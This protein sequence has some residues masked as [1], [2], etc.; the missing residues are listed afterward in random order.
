MIFVL[1]AV[2]GLVLMVLSAGFFLAV[3]FGIQ[4]QD[5]FSGY[6]ALRDEDEHSRLSRTGSRVVGLGYYGP[7]SD[8]ADEHGTQHTP[9]AF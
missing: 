1:T 9:T 2:T 5:R 4:R 7:S 8:G 3:S 6:R